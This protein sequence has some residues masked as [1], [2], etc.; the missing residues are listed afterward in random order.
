MLTDI[1]SGYR[2]DGSSDSRELSGKEPT[3]SPAL[4]TLSPSLDPRDNGELS[5][6]SPLQTTPFTCSLSL[7]FLSWL[8][9]P[10][11]RL[12]LG[13]FLSPTSLWLLL[14]FLG[15]DAFFI[16]AGLNWGLVSAGVRPK[17]GPAPKMAEVLRP[18]HEGSG[19]G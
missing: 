9:S 5:L 19:R 4:S 1:N 18:M 15:S 2:L 17:L 6:V 12:K 10:D 8:K 11:L 14:I 13:L 7:C 3:I 16:G